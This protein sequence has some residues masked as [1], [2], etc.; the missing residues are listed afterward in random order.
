MKKLFLLLTLLVSVHAF[1]QKQNTVEG[2]ITGL[3][4]QKVYLASLYGERV[5]ILD[6]TVSDASGNLKFLLPGG[7]PVGMYRI[8][9]GKE[10]T[11]DLILNKEDVAFSTSV[12]AVSDSLRIST[13]GENAVYYFYMQLDRK[14][15]AALQLLIPVIDYY[16]EGNSFYKHASDEYEIVQKHLSAV[17]DSLV[18]KYPQSFAVRIFRLQQTPFLPATLKKDDRL[19]YLRQHFLDKADF[20]DTLLLRSNAWSNKAIAYLSLYSSSR[21]AQP[22]LQAEFIK[23]V[24]V[25]LSAASVNPYIFKFLLDYYVGGFDKYHFDDVISYMADNF[26]D[27]FACE[28]Q[29]RKSTLQ[30]KLDHFKKLSA[31]KQ[32]PDLEVPDKDGKTVSLASIKSEYTLLIFWS[33]QCSHCVDMMPKVKVL[34]DNQK[35]KR[36]EIMTVSLDTDRKEWVDFI[37]ANKF[38]WLDTSDLKGFA[39]KAADDYNIYASPTMFLLDKDKKI[40]AKP[41]SYRELEG[42]LAELGIK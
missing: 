34:Y 40:L 4:K 30:K 25:M 5:T 32:A 24:T 36:M 31:G 39:G 33:S 16:P 7:L 14:T 18:K 1:S 29:S 19:N 28:D 42:N 37:S 26:Q 35:P 6:S 2:K 9:S 41:V 11:V 15:Q 17:L 10:V 12:F 21:Y 13:P 3:D 23:G 8:I 20:S 38:R 22:Q 27:P